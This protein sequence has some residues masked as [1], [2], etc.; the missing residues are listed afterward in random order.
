MRFLA[1]K[2]ISD[3]WTANYIIKKI[4]NANPT[5]QKPF[6]LGLPTG[7]SAICIYHHM[8][9]AYKQGLVSFEHVVSFNMDEYIGLP[10]THAQSYHYF[11]HEHLFNHVDMRPENIHIPNGM[12]ENINKEAIDYEEKIQNSGG[13]DLFFGGVGQDGHI[14][15]NEPGSSLTS[16]TRIK[17]LTRRTLQ[18][19]ARFFDNDPSKV[20]PT[21]LTVGIQTIMN[22][23]EVIIL[24]QGLHKAL[25][26]QHAV[27]GSINHMWPVS[28]LQMHPNFIMVC[29]EPAAVE[30]RLKTLHYFAQIE[31]SLDATL[32]PELVCYPS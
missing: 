24:A 18:D 23:K 21:A 2:S 16:R 19:N 11:M 7:G 14:A 32:T 6:I 5:A 29:D 10:A 8:V 27:D 9:D 22:A 20:P 12:A 4:N 30:L 31:A 26:V 3:T 17:T 25:A 1:L 28:M 15:F 13:V